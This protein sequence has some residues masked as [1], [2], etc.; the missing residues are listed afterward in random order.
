MKFPWQ[1][2]QDSESVADGSS[3]AAS[4]AHDK[5][6]ANEAATPEESGK[7]VPKGYTP[8]KGRPT[9]KRRDVEIQRGVRRSS[10]RTLSPKAAKEQRKK[11]KESMTKEEWKEYRAKEREK[12]RTARL[13]AQ[14][15]MDAGDERYL[16]ARDKGEE[17]RFTRDWIDSRRFL[18]NFFMPFALLIL[19]VLFVGNWAPKFASVIS[20]LTMVVL[21]IFFVEGM[22]TGRRVNS[23]V[24][25]KFPGTT[26]TGFGLGF[27]AFSRMTQPRRWR[28]PRPR[29]NIGDKV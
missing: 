15:R 5:H 10:E 3:S 1:K 28:S 4:A 14:Q 20:T 16:L 22:V 27:Y 7:S 26:A 13:E 18:N 11:L 29:V 2:S 8:P 23:A 12:S 6:S 24:R 9:P 21:V 25:Q 17:R 19:I